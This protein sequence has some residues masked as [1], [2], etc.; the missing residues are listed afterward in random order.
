MKHKSFIIAFVSLMV[1]FPTF[2]QQKKPASTSVVANQTKKQASTTQKKSEPKQAGPAKHAKKFAELSDEEY[3]AEYAAMKK[4]DDFTIDARGEI[5]WFKK[6]LPNLCVVERFNEKQRNGIKVTS[7]DGDVFIGG[8]SRMESIFE[9]SDAFK[10]IF[11]NKFKYGIPITKET[12]I[13]DIWY[14]RACL[15]GDF[16]VLTF[17]DSSKFPIIYTNYSNQGNYK[18]VKVPY[19]DKPGD[20]LEKYYEIDDYSGEIKSEGYYGDM[21]I[22]FNDCV[23]IG[24]PGY[25]ENTIIYNNGDIYKGS[26]RFFITPDKEPSNLINYMDFP[27]LIQNRPK[28]FEEFAHLDRGTVT[29]TSGEVK[30]IVKGEVDEFESLKRTKEEQAKIEEAKQQK[31]NVAALVA[32]YGKE[33][34]TALA[35][36]T[37]RLGM[38]IE[39]FNIGIISQS[40]AKFNWA[41]VSIENRNSVCYDLEKFGDPNKRVGFVWFENGKVS[42]IVFY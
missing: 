36:G 42:S 32:K 22:T 40:F 12:R 13:E 28:E 17:A 30:V 16:G 39:L 27:T 35:N 29:S 11:T 31:K 19:G 37:L 38:P 20:Y 21:R 23:F 41:T 3:E 24:S 7:Y 1:A 15:S 14:L 4:T 26:L 10:A 34:V 9:Y 18:R 8:C 6:T 33:N 25:S 5:T 2:A